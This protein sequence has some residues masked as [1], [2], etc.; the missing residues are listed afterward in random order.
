MI[1]NVSFCATSIEG[2]M[3]VA[4][5]CTIIFSMVVFIVAFI[6][7]CLHTLILVFTMVCELVSVRNWAMMAVGHCGF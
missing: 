4:C 3:G 2:S 7:I 5:P 6:L 1:G